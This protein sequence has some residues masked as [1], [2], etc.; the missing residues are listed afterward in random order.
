MALA[1]LEVFQ[2]PQFLGFVRN[3]PAPA[4]Y[5]ANRW[6]PNRTVFDLE[7]EYLVGAQEK[8]VMAQILSWDAEA[9][10]APRP[11]LGHKI[12]Q[13]LPPIKRK[14]KIPEK[15]LIRFLQPRANTPDVQSAID[16]VFDDT[17]RLIQGVQARVEWMRMQALSESTLAYNE[18]GIVVTLDYGIDASQQYDVGVDADLSTWWSDTATANWVADLQF[19]ADDMEARTG[20]RPNEFAL[21]KTIIPYM[22]NNTTAKG[23]LYNPAPSRQLVLDEIN[24]LLNLYDLPSLVPYDAKVY[25]EEGDGTVTTLTPLDPKKGV[26]IPADPGILIGET[27]W[28]PTAESRSLI[29]TPRAFQAPGIYA[30]VYGQ[31]DPPSEWIKAAAVAVP[32]MPGANLIGQVQLLNPA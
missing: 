24:Q 17:A 14:A 5:I 9:P 28:G 26:L 15:Q 30:V 11:G 21:S 23:L 16:S 20:F 12:T 10:L 7:V 31:E 19:I 1:E 22:A 25:R 27:L 29:G 32:S 18:D 2:G 8:P 3:V 6:L 13:E 4:P